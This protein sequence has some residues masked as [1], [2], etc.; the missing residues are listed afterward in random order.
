MKIQT[1]FYANTFLRGKLAD[2]TKNRIVE[3]MCRLKLEAKK[4]PGVQN[5][6]YNLFGIR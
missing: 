5:P 6:L 4:V 1:G 3:A 2:V